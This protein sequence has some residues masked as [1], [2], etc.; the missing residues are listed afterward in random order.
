MNRVPFFELKRLYV[1]Q[2]TEI[3]SAVSQVLSSGWYILGKAGESFEAAFGESLAGS[4]ARAVGCNSGTDALILSFLVAGAGP[5]SEIITPSHTAIPTVTAIRSTGATPVFADID[6]D[7]WLLDP[8]RIE[9]L[10]T[11]KTR[12]IVAVHLYGNM[13]ALEPIQKLLRSKGREDIAIIEDVAQAQGSTFNGKQ[14]GTITRL[15]A[16][17]FYPS[18]NV[19]ALGDGGAVFASSAE[20]Q[21]AL[22]TFRNYGQMSRYHAEL[23]HGLNSRLD[24]IQ[25]AILEVRLKKLSEWNRRK[26]AMMEKY[27]SAL[28]G[29]PL[30]FQKVTPGCVPAWHL[31][32]IALESL[33][34]RDALMTHLKD[35]GV[36]TMV[37]YPIPVH[38]QK[39]FQGLSKASLPVTESLA[40]RIV[41]LPMNAALTESEQAQVIDQVLA[42]FKGA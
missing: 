27:R 28:L 18:K 35:Q 39:A 22:R 24:E 31:G 26:T 8:A 17:S 36:E 33:A 30:R 6:A 20:D 41:S 10:I 25:A 12:A 9:N 34:K 38:R 37:H 7:T 32:V 42:F 14:A 4:G 23:D 16:F 3:D 1:E 2:K 13:V 21:K 11:P 15:G 19:G 40:D 5:D 29:L